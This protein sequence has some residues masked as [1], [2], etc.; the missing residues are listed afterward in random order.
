[1][2]PYIEEILGEVGMLTETTP[3]A[4]DLFQVRSQEETN[5]LPKEHSMHFHCNVAQ[6]LFIS[7]RARRDV[8]ASIGFLITSE[9]SMD[10][11][12]W[13]KLKRVIKYLRQDK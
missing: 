2:I 3:M 7:T 11:D 12:D 6:L 9:I 5:L 1:M 4:Y 8:Q 13:R 10:E